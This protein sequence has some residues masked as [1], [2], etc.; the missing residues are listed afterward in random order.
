[1]NSEEQKRKFMEERVEKLIE[2]LQVFF[3]EIDSTKNPADYRIPELM[4]GLLQEAFEGIKKKDSN[5][6]DSKIQN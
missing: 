1:M 3:K 5:M 6:Q 2:C 4:A